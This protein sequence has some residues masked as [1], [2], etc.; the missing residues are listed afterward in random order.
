MKTTTLFKKR[1]SM[2]PNYLR[3][4]AMLMLMVGAMYTQAV[5]GLTHEFIRA[6][7]YNYPAVMHFESDFE[8]IGYLKI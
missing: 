1:R 6:Y 7:A 4:T 8:S 3:K 2:I 5:A